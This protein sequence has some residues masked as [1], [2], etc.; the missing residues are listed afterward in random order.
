LANQLGYVVFSA[1]NVITHFLLRART[2]KPKQ[3]KP[4]NKYLITSPY[5]KIIT[6][7]G[8]TSR[9]IANA[10]KQKIVKK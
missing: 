4:I 3:T 2:K 8:S 9:Q 7:D 6:A 10:T 1:V 5:F